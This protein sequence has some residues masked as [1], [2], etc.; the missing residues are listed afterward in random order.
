[1]LINILFEEKKIESDHTN[2][3]FFIKIELSKFN[4]M[5]LYAKRF[6]LHS[7]LIYVNKLLEISLNC[8]KFNQLLSMQNLV[9]K[10]VNE[11]LV[12]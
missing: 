3:I 12:G 5:I 11:V 6:Q 7:N 2:A 9:T 1:M 10:H 8:H 4:A